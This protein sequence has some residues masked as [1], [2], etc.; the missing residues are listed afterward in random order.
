MNFLFY[1][2]LILLFQVLK[3]SGCWS[4]SYF[5]KKL[6]KPIQK[7]NSFVENLDEKPL[8]IQTPFNKP[9]FSYVGCFAD[10]RESRDIHEKEYTFI[11]KFNKTMPTVE[12]CVNLCAQDGFSVAG[13]QAL[14]KDFLKFLKIYLIFHFEV[15]NVFAE[16]LME[17]IMPLKIQIVFLNVLES[18]RAGVMMP[19]LSILYHVRFLSFNITI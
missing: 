15:M 14:Y 5:L 13:I 3:F 9:I 18:I 10:K 7:K 11:T 4:D 19:T 6:D 1:F 2:K 12:L 16:T 8:K 17:N